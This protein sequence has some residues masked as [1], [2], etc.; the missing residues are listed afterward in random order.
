MDEAISAYK[1]A[2]EI[3][4]EFPAAHYFIGRVYLQQNRPQEA[5]AELEREAEPAFRVQGLALGYYALGRKKDSDATLAE[6]IAKYQADSAFQVA[7]IYALRG[8][9]DGAFEWLER[10]YTQRDG[11]LSSMTGDP[12]LKN[13]EHDPRYAAFLKKMHLPL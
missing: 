11:G 9:S 7:E 13:I 6:Y 2:L 10:A 1:K 5:L 3:N 12:L 4:P 8:E